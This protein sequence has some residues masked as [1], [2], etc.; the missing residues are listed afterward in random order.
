MIR[1]VGLGPGNYEA[2]TIGTIEAL[3]N[4]PYTILRTEKHPTVEYLKKEGIVYSTYDYAYEK[5]DSFDEV[6]EFIANDV[7]N[8][9]IEHGDIIYAVPGHP[10]V[11]EKSVSLIIDHCKNNGINYEVIPAVSF[12][13]VIMES[14][15][16]DPIEG[17]KI[18]DAFDIKNQV[19]DKRTGVVISQVYDKFIASEV[20]LNLLSYYRDDTEIY[21]IRAAG[22]KDMEVVKKISLYE[23]DRQEEIDH[24]TSIY[25]PKDENNGKDFQDLINI[26]DTLIGENGCPWDREQTHESIKRALIEESYEAV[27]A[28]DQKDD[29]KIVEEL[30]D[31]LFQ[32]VF[33]AALG[34]EEGYYNIND[35]IIAICDKMILRHPHVFGTKKVENSD[36]VLVNWDEIKKEEN[37]YETITDEMKHIA[38]I[39]PALIRA[40]KIQNKAKKVNF[41]WDKVE[42]ALDKVKEEY[43]E[44]KEVYKGKNRARI[45]EEM[46]DLLFSIV[47]VARFMNL[48]SEEALNAAS[49]KFIRRFDYMEKAALKSGVELKDMTLE[50]MNSL[51]EESK[52]KKLDFKEGI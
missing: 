12:I 26:M 32:V 14:L 25:I 27:E 4:C 52:I 24:L 10:L 50:Q 19:M 21:F 17:F 7:I 51:W 22:I 13:D 20:K 42:G 46:G 23:L 44:L 47:N 38:R 9:W 28:I 3:K 30:G 36:E 6:Y 11:A 5:F 33:H 16:I 41:D 34:K 43:I 31:V 15:E 1:I 48:D 29:D 49:D 39:L 45:L 35:I 40:E 8:K 18:I 2:L 37:G